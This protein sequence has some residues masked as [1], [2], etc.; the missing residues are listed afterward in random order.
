MAGHAA[1]TSVSEV[2]LAL[3]PQHERHI[4][5]YCLTAGQGGDTSFSGPTMF[6]EFPNKHV[7]FILDDHDVYAT[8]D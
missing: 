5:P 3:L 6:C 8:S 7:F 1:R 2:R 4:H